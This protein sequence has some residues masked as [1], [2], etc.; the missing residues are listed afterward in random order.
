MTAAIHQL[1]THAVNDVIRTTQFLRLEVMLCCWALFVTFCHHLQC[2]AFLLDCLPNRTA[3]HLRKPESA[4]QFAFCDNMYAIPHERLQPSGQTT[5]LTTRHLKSGHEK[6]E[7][8]F[9][10]IGCAVASCLLAF[11]HCYQFSLV[12]QG[13]FCPELLSFFLGIDRWQQSNAGTWRNR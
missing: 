13:S 6:N 1:C 7:H 11:A 8:I 3:S 9:F 12:L 10:I 2:P 5:N 4:T